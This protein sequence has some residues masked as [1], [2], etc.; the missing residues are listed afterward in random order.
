MRSEMVLKSAVA[1][2]SKTAYGLVFDL[3][4]ASRL[5]A[6]GGKLAKIFML[7]ALMHC[8][9]STLILPQDRGNLILRRIGIVC[10]KM[11]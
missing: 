1:R 11:H 4:I 7:A 9:R 2:Q 10:K 3:L 5:I 6:K 8:S